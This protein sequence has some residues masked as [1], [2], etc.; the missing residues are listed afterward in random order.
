MKQEARYEGACPF[1]PLKYIA[2]YFELNTFFHWQPMKS[3]EHVEIRSCMILLGSTKNKL[4]HPILE[5]L[6]FVEVIYVGS[7][8]KLITI[9]QSG[10]NKEKSDL[11][12]LLHVNSCIPNLYLKYVTAAAV[13]DLQGLHLHGYI[14]DLAL[15][16]ILTGSTLKYVLCCS[17][18][19]LTPDT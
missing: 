5:A 17:T 11:T 9:I 8:Q 3:I 6:K 16:Y 12:T 10:Q 7:K 18:S 4:C 13:M 15:I 19:G 1:K 2:Q 14:L